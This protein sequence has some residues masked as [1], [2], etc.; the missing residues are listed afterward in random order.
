MAVQE[1]L[2]V[3]VDSL[4]SKTSLSHSINGILGLPSV[5][6]QLSSSQRD[7]ERNAKPD[8]QETRGM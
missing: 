4:L 3:R 1:V 2:R 6:K 5:Y 7:D 8:E